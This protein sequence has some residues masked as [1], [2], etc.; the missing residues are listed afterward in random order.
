MSESSMNMATTE[1]TET[2][3]KSETTGSAENFDELGIQESILRGVYAYGFEKPSQIQV[4]AI[5][6]LI[7]GKDIVAQ[8]QSGTGK[9][10]AFS[11]GALSKVD[12]S[13]ECEY[14]WRGVAEKS[15]RG[16]WDSGAYHRYVE[17]SESGDI[18]DQYVGL[19]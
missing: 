9:T 14:V 5:P 6:H 7:A 3:E 19:G 17:S 13:L 18:G 10:G 12:D 15:S 16:D 2:T 8:A 11:I 4:K 1:T